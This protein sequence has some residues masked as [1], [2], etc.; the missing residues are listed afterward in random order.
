MTDDPKKDHDR[1]RHVSAPVNNTPTDN[2]SKR[3]YFA[4]QALIG[5][6]GRQKPG[7]FSYDE[8]SYQAFIMAD[9]MLRHVKEK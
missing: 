5:L 2:I 6:I 4:G 1:S 9:A 8:M 3:N 7:Y